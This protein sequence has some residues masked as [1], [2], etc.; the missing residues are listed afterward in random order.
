MNYCSQDFH[1]REIGICL[2][3]NQKESLNDIGAD[4]VEFP[5][6]DI[7]SL[8]RDEYSE[9][10]T[11][12][13]KNDVN[14]PAMTQLL[15]KKGSIVLLPDQ[16]N[17]YKDFLSFGFERAKELGTKIVIFGNAGSRNIPNSEMAE[18]A[19]DR[20]VQF[21]SQ[22]ADLAEEYDIG[23]C[24]E[25][26]NRIQ[27]NMINTVDEA[28]TVAN[29]SG[30]KNVGIVW[31]YF[32]FLVEKDNLDSISKN[33]ELIKHCHTAALLRRGIPRINDQIVFFNML[34]DINYS[35]RISLEFD[36]LPFETE[37]IAEAITTFRL[38][39]N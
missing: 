22:T 36:R 14:C 39:N 8:S 28:A 30:K 27:S 2:K 13:E 20:I 19:L 15:P 38:T 3:V 31:D 9:F 29:R 25:P 7:A 37:A 21:I 5:F 26:L 16:F 34:K 23:I 12:I 33:K 24:I 4:Y 35:G 6:A 18:V 11:W 32:H 17:M 1:K 10:R